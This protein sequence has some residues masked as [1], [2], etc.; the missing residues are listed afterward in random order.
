MMALTKPYIIL[1]SA[2]LVIAVFFIFT[3][4][5]DIKEENESSPTAEALP[6]RSMWS[7][8]HFILAAI[9]Q[10]LYVAAQTGIFSFF[11]N[12][13]T[14]LD[15]TIT[16]LKAS[17]FLAFGGM[18]LFM[19]GRLS[20]SFIM[21]KFKA[22]KL[23]SIYSLMCCLMMVLVMME[24]GKVSLYALYTTFFFM[25]NGDFSETML[26]TSFDWN[27]IRAP[28]VFAT[29]DD[30][31]NCITMLFSN[32]L[33]HRAQIFADVRTYWSPEAIERVSGWKPEGILENGAIHLIN[34]GA[35]L[36]RI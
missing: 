21:A 32:L 3:K 11:I 22:H 23:L 5:P 17:R 4:L 16:P 35:C 19:I 24:L 36:S 25:P 27:G 31:L 14:E 29:E 28:F 20:G 33:T 10:F 6:Q 30:H 2:V 12:Y 15:T 34:S 8:K 18:L 1:G 13:V 9:A 26:N 7:Y